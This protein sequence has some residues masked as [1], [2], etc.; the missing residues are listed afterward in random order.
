MQTLTSTTI[1]SLV[2]AFTTAQDA[3]EAEYQAASEAL[4]DACHAAPWGQQPGEHGRVFVRCFGGWPQDQD[5][6]VQVCIDGLPVVTITFGWDMDEQAAAL[7]AGV[8]DADEL[9]RRAR[10]I[11][12]AMHDRA[13]ER[14][15][16]EA[17]RAVGRAA[18]EAYE[19][20]LDEAAGHIIAGRC[21]PRGR[22]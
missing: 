2:D 20:L 11:A 9:D 17:R 10:T 13:A 19:A 12:V 6:R 22:L 5:R 7:E 3:T 4:A 1:L 18:C 21:R 14:A 15:G 16:R 8:L